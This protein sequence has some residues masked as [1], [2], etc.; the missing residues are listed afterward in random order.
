MKVY[1]LWILRGP[2]ARLSYSPVRWQCPGTPPPTPCASPPGQHLA[3]TARAK[4]GER[5]ETKAGKQIQVPPRWECDKLRQHSR[6][7]RKFEFSA[8]SRFGRTGR[9]AQ[10]D[11][12]FTAIE[13]QSC[14]WRAVTFP[15]LVHELGTNDCG[16]QPS[17]ALHGNRGSC[18]RHHLFDEALLLKPCLEPLHPLQ[19]PPGFPMRMT[20][21]SSHSTLFAT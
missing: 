15:V 2:C 17:G 1:L 3:T 10:Q 21:Y 13:S 8:P 14:W 20:V 11:D 4:E 18:R 19:A 5:G 7:G 6:R 16:L 12:A 9:Q